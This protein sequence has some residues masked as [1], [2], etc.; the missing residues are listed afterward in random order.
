MMIS[1]ENY[2]SNCVKV[3]IIKLCKHKYYIYMEVEILL[4]FTQRS[5]AF[6]SR[7]QENGTYS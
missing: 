5:L 1:L 7:F 4:F 3:Y 2:A 6:I